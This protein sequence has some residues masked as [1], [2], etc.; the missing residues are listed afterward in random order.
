I[1]SSMGSQNLRTLSLLAG[2][3]FLGSGGPACAQQSGGLEIVPVRGHIY[4]LAGAGAN[5]TLSVGPDGVLMVDSGEAALT[6]KVLAAINQLSKAVATEGRPL[7][8][9]APPK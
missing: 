4:M 9:Y 3:V 6:G 7:S 1:N 5:I 2:A 8:S